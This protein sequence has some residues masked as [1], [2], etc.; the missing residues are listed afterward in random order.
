VQRGSGGDRFEVVPVGVGTVPIYEALEKVTGDPTKLSWEVHRD[1]VIEQCE[2]AVD[3]VTVHAAVLL[4][5]VPLTV[6]RVTGTVFRGGSIMAAWCLAQH[7]PGHVLDAHQSRASRLRPRA[8]GAPGSI[9]RRPG[10]WAVV[11]VWPI[12][13]GVAPERVFRRLAARARERGL[14]PPAALS[15]EWF[16]SRTVLVPSVAVTPRDGLPELA[17]LPRPAAPGVGGGWIGYLGVGCEPAVGRLP[18]AAWGWT[19]HVLRCDHTG[20]WWFE[21]LSP[22]AEALAAEFAALLTGPDPHRAPRRATVLLR[23]D[24]EAHRAAVRAC[25]E[26]IAAGEIFQANITT[27]F[28]GGFTG[29]PAELFAAGT[30]RLAPMRAAFLSGTWGSCVSL[31]PELFLARHDELVRSAPIKGTRPR[32]GMADAGNAALLRGSAKDTAENVMI[33]DM[34]RN[35]LGRVCTPGSVVVPE[36]LAVRPAP[37]VW[38]LSSTVEGRLR[39]GVTDTDLLAATFPPPS[40][41]GTPKLRALEVI[42]EIEHYPREIYSGAI[43]M[44]SPV[45][46]LE[47]G[48]AIRTLEFHGKDVWLGVGGGITADSHPDTE[49]R[50]CLHK[51]APLEALLRSG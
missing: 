14:P 37:G 35:D 43:G 12:G 23:P 20:R 11:W 9:V 18:A 6:E 5:Y 2:Q 47:L 36:L 30:A 3:Y 22:G 40:V 29:D 32:R 17:R 4:S 24:A 16:G 48:V 8:N 28:V 33:V 45:A 31:S 1:T 21:S 34:T 13:Q 39:P 42:A 50:E 41:T 27:R 38:H 10:S 26:T 25:I 49:W 46:G 44:L 51:A 7:G 15:G 19:D